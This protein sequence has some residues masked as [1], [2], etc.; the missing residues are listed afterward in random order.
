MNTIQT[1]SAATHVGKDP[2]LTWNQYS[3]G[4]KSILKEGL[5]LNSVENND[6]L[7]IKV[8]GGELQGKDIDLAIRA[9]DRFLKTK[10]AEN[11][12]TDSVNSIGSML[13][14]E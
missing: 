6:P 13:G 7:L 5:E 9:D 1:G 12:F 10:R 2:T 3:S 14:F 4:A 11:E 8:L